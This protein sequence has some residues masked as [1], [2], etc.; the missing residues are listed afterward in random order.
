MTPWASP[1]STASSGSTGPRLPARVVLQVLRRPGQLPRRRSHLLRVRRDLP[2]AAARLARSSASSSRATRSCRRSARL[3]AEHIPD[4]RRRSSAG[5]RACTGSMTRRVVGGLAAIYGSLG[6][7]QAAPERHQRRL[8]G[9]PQQPA[10]PVPAAAQEP[11]PAGHRRAVGAR[12]SRSSHAS[13]ATPRC[14]VRASTSTMRWAS[15]WSPC[16]WSPAR[17]HG[18]V[19]ARRRPPAPLLGAR[20]AR[21]VHGGVLWQALQFVGTLYVDRCWP[22]QRA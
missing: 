11:A 15:G 22:D 10:Q 5:P 13:A 17:A 7:G 9:A 3:G 2:A 4:H 20:R 19:P 18:A 8:V 1:G 12:R 16:C 6:L 14:S 21:G